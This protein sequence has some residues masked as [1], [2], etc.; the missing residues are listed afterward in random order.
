MSII[1]IAYA[2][3]APCE[4]VIFFMMMDA[5]FERRRQFK[6]WQYVIGVAILTVSIRIVNNYLLFRVGNAFG[7]VLAAVLV[8]LFFYQVSWLKRIFVLFFS[9]AL[10]IGTIETLVMNIICLVFEITANESLNTPEY[11]VLGIFVSKFLG[12]AVGYALCVKSKFKKLE[13]DKSYWVL[14][15]FLF[16]SAI[17][18]VFL[19]LGMLSELNNADYNAMAMISCIGLFGSVFLA[20]F[21]YAHSQQQNQTIRYQEQAEQQMRS[22]LKHMDEIILNQNEIRAMRHDMNS[23]LITLKGYFDTEDIAK[24][25]HYTSNLINQFQNITPSIDTGNNALDSIISAKRALAESKGII[26]NSKIRIQKNLPIDPGDISVIFGNALDNSIEA[27]DRLPENKKKI[28]NVLL[29][30]DSTVILC[31]ISNT[32]PE[33]TSNFF[34]STK[35]D[36]VN[37]GFGLNN[38]QKA[39]EKYPAIVDYKQIGDRFTFSFAIFY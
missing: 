37:H 30:Q 18:T 21:L 27:C 29:Q 20:L 5:F 32:A 17:I 12:V 34:E 11:L 36:K 16:L 26:F 15:I 14:F 22:Q 3:T 9:W 23:H 35:M 39:L 13:L 25:K 33:K 2:L 28:I 31:K 19:I 38:M 6:A 7:M 10:L 1:D 4:A 8:S 24:G